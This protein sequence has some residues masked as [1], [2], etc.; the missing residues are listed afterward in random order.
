MARSKEDCKTEIKAFRNELD[1][2][3]DELEK[4]MLNLPESQEYEAQKSIGENILTLA[5]TL[6]TF[7]KHYT[8]SIHSHSKIDAVISKIKA[9]FYDCGQLKT[10]RNAD[11]LARSQEHCKTFQENGMLECSI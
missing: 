10:I 8:L 6:K 3:F 5:T 7:Q 11:S 1:I 4:P 2:I 9:F